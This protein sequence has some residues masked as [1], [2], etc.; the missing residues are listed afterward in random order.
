VPQP[1]ECRTIKIV[2]Q[3]RYVNQN[4]ESYC[5]TDS[6]KAQKTQ[7]ETKLELRMRT[8]AN[9]TTR[10]AMNVSMR[11]FAFWSSG[12]LSLA[13]RTASTGTAPVLPATGFTYVVEVHDSK[14][15]A[16]VA[17]ATEFGS[18]Y[19]LWIAPCANKAAIHVLG[20]VYRTDGELEGEFT[21]TFRCEMWSIGTPEP[22]RKFTAAYG[23]PTLFDTQIE[24]RPGQYKLRVVVT[25]GKKFGR[26]QMP[27]RVEP[28]DTQALTVS[29]LVLSS[30]LRDS[31]WIVRDA[32]QVT[33]DPLVPAPLVSKN[34]EF[35]PVAD[36][37]VRNR[38]PLSVYFEIY[39]PLLNTNKV[40]VSYSLKITDRKTDSLVM[41]T[42]PMSAAGWVVPGNA[43]IPIGLKLAIEKL[44]PGPYR[45][46]LQASDSAGRESEWRQAD[47]IIE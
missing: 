12:M 38:I 37:Q 47:F 6:S 33:P 22:I 20:M 14:A 25:D 13:T 10:G 2:V 19:Q 34:V 15:P 1:G 31:S 5:A 9:S 28:L 26:A 27:L 23:I 3:N 11:Y 40:D 21:D 35:L 39:E 46:E 7:E 44:P 43:V 24:L 29:D 32:A 36:V 42:G 16:T 45:I 18:P 4:R 17:I 30:I 8:F 41:N